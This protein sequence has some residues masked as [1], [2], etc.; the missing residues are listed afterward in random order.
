MMAL[1][2]LRHLASLAAILFASPLFAVQD[3]VRTPAGSLAG[4]PGRNPDVR[5][6]KA[7]PYAAPPVGALRWKPPQPA[8]PWQGVRTADKFSDVCEQLPY[9]SGSIYAFA[10]ESMSEDCLYLNVWTAAKSANEKRP[11]MVWIHG[12]AL[13][14]GSGST[15]TYDGESLAAKGVVLVTINYRLGV[16]GFLAHP[17]LTA[18]SDHKASGNYG[19]LDQIAA[20]EWVH[21]NIAAFGGDPG[22][23]T[24][25][26]ESAGSWSVNVLVASPLAK[27]L[28]HRAIGESGGNFGPMKRLSEVEQ[29]GAKFAASVGADRFEALRSKPA[30]DLTKASAS[31]AFAANV[32]GWLLSDDVYTIF[33]S[34]KQNDVP[35]IIGSNANEATSLAPWPPSGTAASFA[36]QLRRRFGADADKVLAVYPAKTD[37]EAQQAHYASFRDV[38]FTWQMRTWARLAARTGKSKVFLYYFSRVPPGPASSRYGA[39]HAAEI[40]YAFNNLKLGKRPNEPTDFDLADKMSSYWTNFAQS[41]DPNGPGL[42][43]WPA[44]NEKTDLALELGDQIKPVSDLHKKSLDFWD[45]YFAG[46]RRKQAR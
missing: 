25:F 6:Y 17:E 7:I 27:G 1:M 29:S 10:A 33:A 15:P 23:V 18:E 19:F 28:F 38:T 21:N 39:F 16:F 5:V 24:I 42:P 46:L 44:Y 14:R 43:P 45:S 40:A 8:A 13:T 34:G 22:R 35:V 20:L 37:E 36:D 9:P 30:A 4:T 12:G 3:P 31:A 2:H 32:D 11:V 26:G 41:G